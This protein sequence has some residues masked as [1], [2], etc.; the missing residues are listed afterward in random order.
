MKYEKNKV[1]YYVKRYLQEI[2]EAFIAYSIYNLLKEKTYNIYKML[3]VS[4]IIGAVT[5]FL[6]EYNE[7]YKKN[8]KNGLITSISTSVY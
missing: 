1:L 3:K 4:L 5:L 6:E 8:I 7:D 2:L